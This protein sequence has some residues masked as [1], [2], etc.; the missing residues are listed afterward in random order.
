MTPSESARRAVVLSSSDLPD[1]QQLLLHGCEDCACPVSNDHLT[2]RSHAPLT[3]VMAEETPWVRA[4]ELV[5]FRLDT[6]HHLLFNPLGR[7]GVAVVNEPARRVLGCFQRPSTFSDARERWAGRDEDFEDLC[8]R[9]GHLEMIQPSGHLPQLDFKSSTVLTAWLHVTNACNL[10]CPYCYVSKSNE[11]MD[12]STGRAAVEAVIRSAVDHGFSAVKLK[13]AGG[14]A[15]LNHRLV[16]GLHAYAQAMAAEHELE[17]YATL[18]S[19]GVAL[20]PT[21]VEALRSAGIRVMVSLDGVGGQHDAQRPFANGRPS[22]RF[23]ERTI[24]RLIE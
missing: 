11:G 19:N 20:S 6:D 14:E 1:A 22:F 8:G 17:L 7:G 12:E 23:V 5:E 16:L 9:L 24:T 4:R 10:R 21:L 18:L 15:S 2:S 3:Q 13:Y